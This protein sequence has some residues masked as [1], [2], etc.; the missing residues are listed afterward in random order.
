[1][2]RRRS[3]SVSAWLSCLKAT[4]SAAA[5]S[6]K[7]PVMALGGS[8]CG[9]LGYS[10]AKLLAFLPAWNSALDHSSRVITPSLSRSSK[11]KM[12]TSPLAVS[13]GSPGNG[14]PGSDDTSCG[15]DEPTAAERVRTRDFD[16]ASSSSSSACSH[17]LFFSTSCCSW[18]TFSLDSSRPTGAS[19][20]GEKPD[21]AGERG[22]ELCSP[23]SSLRLRGRNAGSSPG[24]ASELCSCF[25]LR[26]Y[27]PL[28]Y[29]LC[30]ANRS[31]TWVRSSLNVSTERSFSLSIPTSLWTASPTRRSNC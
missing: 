31:S 14:P 30:H 26:A 12:S 2:M 13:A 8:K 10:P 20:A 27:S 4:V 11:P 1:M 18:R 3:L 22:L 6:E 9:S 23:Q 28:R 19:P 7:L 21:A 24:R 29:R 5:S 16:S 15:Q 25:T 17:C